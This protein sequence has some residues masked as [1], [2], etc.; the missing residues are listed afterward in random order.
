MKR[1]IKYLNFLSRMKITKK[2][3]RKELIPEIKNRA[4]LLIVLTELRKQ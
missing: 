1:I 4:S 2:E 3:H